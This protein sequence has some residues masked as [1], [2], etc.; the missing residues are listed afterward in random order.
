MAK[1]T[2]FESTPNNLEAFW[3][4]FTANRQFKAAPRD[5][6]PHRNKTVVRLHHRERAQLMRLRKLSDRRQQRARTQRPRVDSASKALHQLLDEGRR[7]APVAF[8][9]KFDHRGEGFMHHYSL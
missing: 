7:T 9:L 3:M 4:P 1:T 5:H 8:Q 6:E 2:A